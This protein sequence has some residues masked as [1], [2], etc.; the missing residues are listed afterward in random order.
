MTP[1]ERAAAFCRRFGLAAPMIEAPMAGACPPGL[2]ASVAGAGGMGALGAVLTPPRGI[3]E[4]V[5]A[6]RAA[7]GG[8]LQINLWIPHAAPT[9]DPQAETALRAFLGRWGPAVAADAGEAAPP[10]FAAQC[11]AVLAARP[12]AIS[13][14]MGLFPADFVARCKSVGIAWF[15]CATTLAEARAAGAA[16]ADAVVAQ[17]AEAGGHRGSFDPAAAESQL[18]GLVSLVPRLADALAIPVIATGGIADGRGVAAALAL[19]ASAAQVGSAFLR[20]PESGAHATWARSLGAIEPEETILTRAYSG[21]LGRAVAN[22]YALAAADSAGPRPAPYPVQRGLTSAM[23]AAAL[24]TGD[25]R[26][27]QMWAGQSAALG[28]AT[29]A[30][31]L[32]RRLWRDAEAI[33]A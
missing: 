13:S 32:T 1:K 16:G 17:G 22:D 2:A 11:E 28:L 26:T 15:A 6:F 5:A 27:M 21:R 19:G 25:R 30:G 9:R 8:P 14:I 4:W 7:G 12:T 20:S 23:R 10:D 33:L 29:P 24:A 31:E 18:V 3:A